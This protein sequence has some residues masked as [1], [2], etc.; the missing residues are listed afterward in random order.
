IDKD[1]YLENVQAA[2]LSKGAG[3]RFP[4]DD[5]FRAAFVVKDVYN[6]SRRNYLLS[7]LEGHNRKEQVYVEGYTIEHIM[8]QNGR[9]SATWQDELGEDWQEVHTRYLHT[10]GNL[11][12]TGYN[13]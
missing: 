7:K 2:L 13:S 4:R 8:P 11:T 5:E 3:G 12:L 9:L 1:H 10:I 6:Y